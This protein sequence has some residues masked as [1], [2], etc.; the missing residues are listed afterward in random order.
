[1]KVSKEAL[2]GIIFALVLGVVLLIIKKNKCN[3]EVIYKPDK[4]SEETIRELRKDISKSDSSIL[5]WKKMY[6]ESENKEPEII[7]IYVDK[8]KYINRADIHSNDSML[9]ASLGIGN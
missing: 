1:M 4:A 8:I 9:R 2:Y 7:K 5:Y 3:P 6:D